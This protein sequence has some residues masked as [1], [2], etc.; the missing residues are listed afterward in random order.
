MGVLPGAGTFYFEGSEVGCLLIHGFTGTPQNIRPRCPWAAQIRAASAFVCS[1]DGVMDVCG[2]R[3]MSQMAGESNALR[4]RLLGGFR[5]E[6]DTRVIADSEWR[7]Q[8]ARG[9]VKLLALAP[10]RRLAREEVMDR[11]WPEAEPQAALNNIEHVQSDATD[12]RVDSFCRPRG[13]RVTPGA[14]LRPQCMAPERR[15]GG[16]HSGG[17]Q[18]TVHGRTGLSQRDAARRQWN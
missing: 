8:K 9:L 3:S 11:L 10:R 1:A 4:I 16:V 14:G 15:V 12:G 7:L 5:A 18:P 17:A 6:L 2:T 13:H